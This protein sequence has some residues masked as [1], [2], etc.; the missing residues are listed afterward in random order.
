MNKVIKALRDGMVASVVSGTATTELV[1]AGSDILVAVP[2]G[3]SKFM[4]T[5]I[6]VVANKDIDFFTEVFEDS[7]KQ[8]SFYIKIKLMRL[9]S[10]YKIILRKYP[11]RIMR[12]LSLILPTY[13]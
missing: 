10:I 4:L 5:S 2:M 1:P 11:T 13:I 12:I 6:D 7:S 9:I 3:A 8:K